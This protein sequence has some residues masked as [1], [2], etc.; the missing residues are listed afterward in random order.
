MLFVWFITFVMSLIFE[1]MGCEQASQA[2]DLVSL[3]CIMSYLNYTSAI[4]FYFNEKERRER[5][6]DN[7]T[8]K[9]A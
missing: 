9:T 4:R 2:C 6:K 3:I 1:S 8:D 5:K 7:G